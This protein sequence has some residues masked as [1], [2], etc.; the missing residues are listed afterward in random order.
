M[1]WE[2][3]KCASK[4]AGARKA[5]GGRGHGWRGRSTE[6]VE[7]GKGR[8]RGRGRGRGAGE[9]GSESK[10]GRRQLGVALGADLGGGG[11]YRWEG[12]GTASSR[13]E[14]AWGRGARGKMAGNERKWSAGQGK[15]AAGPAKARKASAV[16]RG[17]CRQ[18]ERRLGT[19]SG[20]RRVVTA[21]GESRC[22]RQ[23]CSRVGPLQSYSEALIQLAGGN[24]G[25]NALALS[26]GLSQVAEK[27]LGGRPPPPQSFCHHRHEGKAGGCTLLGCVSI[28]EF[29]CLVGPG[30]SQ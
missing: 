30:C 12:Q 7:E 21:I 20:D 22:P 8:G 17:S 3:R 15:G 26:C 1:G 18:H 27:G 4:R 13:A 11:G 14:G 23:D 29:V 28:L 6:K 24:A 10:G 19:R 5:G 9:W 2:W 25:I 16:E